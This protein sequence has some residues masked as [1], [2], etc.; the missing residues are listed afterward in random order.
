MRHAEAIAERVVRLG[1]EPATQPAAIAIGKTAAC[2]QACLRRPDLLPPGVE[3]KSLGHSEYQYSMPGMKQPLRV[4]TNPEFFDEHA[5]ST[6]LW[7]PGSPLFP[8]PDDALPREV[9]EAGDPRLAVVCVGR[10]HRYPGSAAG[11]AWIAPDFDE[12]PADLR[13]MGAPAESAGNEQEES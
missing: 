9:V 3:V 13:E 8:A 6:E 4:T 10:S 5:G 12:T 11:Q 1:G 7:S 2:S